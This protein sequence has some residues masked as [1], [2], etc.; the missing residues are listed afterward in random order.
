LACEG[1]GEER[2]REEGGEEE[3]EAVLA[4]ERLHDCVSP[5]SKAATSPATMMLA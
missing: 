1:L 2:H 4:E 5:T 3:R